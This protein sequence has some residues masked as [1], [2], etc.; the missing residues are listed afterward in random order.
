MHQNGS[1]TKCQNNFIKS[2]AKEQNHRTFYLWKHRKH[3][4]EVYD[5]TNEIKLPILSSELQNIAQSN[6]NKQ[7]QN[8]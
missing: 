8:V 7:L 1:C 4:Y 6:L 2:E 3:Q 5:T